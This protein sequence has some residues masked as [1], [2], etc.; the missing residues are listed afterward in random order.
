MSLNTK[1]VLITG[2]SKRLGLELALRTLHMGFSVIIHYRSDYKNLQNIIPKQFINQVYFIQQELHNKPE[3]LIEKAL[4]IPPTLVGLINNASIFEEGN[5][6]NLTHLQKILDINS[7][8]PAILGTHF[9]TTV[10]NGWIINIT[11][12]N[13]KR[14]NKRFQN[15][16]ISKLLL[17]EI[18]K[19]Q[20]YLFA[21]HIRVNAIAPGAM[22][23]GKNEDEQYFE[24]L[25]ENIPLGV[26]GDIGSLIDAYEFLVKTPYITGEI[27]HIDGGWHLVT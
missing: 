21:P 25:A 18:T 4:Q 15:Y 17:E 24:T 9:Y 8:I 19:Q 20:A 12:A 7:L 5:L 27:L 2:G 22:L 16:R 11:D 6:L 26:T 1:A 14:P 10:K 13:L 23:P 3:T